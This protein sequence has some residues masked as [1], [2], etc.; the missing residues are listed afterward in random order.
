MTPALLVPA[1]LA[2]LAAL[3]VPLVIHIARRSEQ[4]PTD[5]A[6]LRWLREKPRPRYRIRFDERLLLALRL[7]LLALLGLWLAHPV[8]FGA[9]D[10]R[11]V[12]AVVPGVDPARVAAGEARR[13][14]LAPGFPALDEPA[15]RAPV[16]SLVRQ[17][18]AELTPVARL[19]IVVPETLQGV[20]GARLRLSRTVTWRVVPGAMA[21]ARAP[22]VAPPELVVRGDGSGLRYLRA[23]AASWAVPPKTAAVSVAGVETPV[24]EN[25]RYLVWLSRAEIPEAVSRWVREGG[26][27]LLASDTPTDAAMPEIAY[28]RD[29]TGA[30]LIEGGPVGLGRMLRFTRALTPAAMPEV[31]DASF[32]AQLRRVLQPAPPPAR[33]F[34]R[35]YAPE[36]GAEPYPQ[37]PR[38]LRP[39]LALLIAGLFL[40]ERW[41]ATSRAR[42]VAP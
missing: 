39:W 19:T 22:D 9:G 25:A 38:D 8:L 11:E 30:A 35:D 31:L 40:M 13:V 33:V 34:A 26:T 1:A 37:P 27:I 6:A 20:D 36:A 21:V 32:A 28:W 17:L 12:V 24:P 18:D 16:A 3:I 10:A 7:A 42:G 5:F 23:A 15:T 4:N 29:G 41:F 2:A 14:W